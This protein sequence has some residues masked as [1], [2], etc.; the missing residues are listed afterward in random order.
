[1]KKL[2]LLFIISFLPL[3]AMDAVTHY[4]WK[5]TKPDEY[6]S[7]KETRELYINMKDQITGQKISDLLENTI[8]VENLGRLA[9]RN[10][11]AISLLV[12]K[13]KSKKTIE[14]QKILT[15]QQFVLP[16]YLVLM[17]VNFLKENMA[18]SKIQLE[19]IQKTLQSPTY[20][21]LMQGH[22]TDNSITPKP[23]SLPPIPQATNSLAEHKV[24]KNK[25]KRKLSS[26]G[27]FGKG[28]MKF[29]KDT[30]EKK[31]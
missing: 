19:Q 27:T 13:I 12:E 17:A 15:E 10:I 22:S 24:S 5:K 20:A 1:M 26:S 3:E 8:F 30:D 14:V 31:D 16:D 7:S 23:S 21:R 9:E 29:P 25:V 4:V 18:E 11:N 2:S 6:L 28:G